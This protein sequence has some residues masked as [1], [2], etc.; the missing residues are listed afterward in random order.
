MKYLKQ[1]ISFKN[2]KCKSIENTKKYGL[3]PDGRIYDQKAK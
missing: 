1:E 2:Y 3:K